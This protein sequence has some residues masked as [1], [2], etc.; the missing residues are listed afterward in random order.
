[1][2]EFTTN[3]KKVL[4]II[5]EHINFEI[6]CIEQEV[7][8]KGR[9]DYSLCS[10][11]SEKQKTTKKKIQKF[12]KKLLKCNPSIS[13]FINVLT[14]NKSKSYDYYEIKETIIRN[15]IL[16]FYQELVEELAEVV[17][18]EE[19][20]FPLKEL[21]K[22]RGFSYKLMKDFIESVA[23][24]HHF[25]IYKSLLDIP[26]NN[27]LV[28]NDIVVKIN[29]AF[30]RLESFANGTLTEYKHFDFDT[31]FSELFYITKKP[32]NYTY[33]NCKLINQYWE[34]TEQIRIDYDKSNFKNFSALKNKA[35]CND[36]D[37]ITSINWDRI[38]QFNEFT[39]QDEIDRQNKKK[40]IADIIN[41]DKTFQKDDKLKDK[42]QILQKDLK[43]IVGI[44]K[45]NYIIKLLEDLSITSKGKSTL[46][47]R[48]KGALRGVVEALRETKIIPNIG[49]AKLCNVIANEIKLD[50]KSE[51]DASNTSEDYK[52]DTLSY[53]KNNPFH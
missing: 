47:P 9:L 3:E 46:T 20:D 12:K 6:F 26:E 1:M 41:F 51:L 42:K 49:L 31:A 14:S 15:F 38:E 33:E 37:V 22:I 35:F 8:D 4:D 28:Y 25:L 2:A 5:V 27:K 34:L 36:C 52:K 30:F 7:R 43:S 44:E 16:E 24:A 21:M 48:K 17:I 32:I 40:S 39:T 45:F 50:L 18:K 53:I 11:L 23:D 19:F 13:G 29:N 10:D